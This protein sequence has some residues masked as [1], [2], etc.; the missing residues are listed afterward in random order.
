MAVPTN[1]LQ[2]GRKVY[3]KKYRTSNSDN[4]VD[5]EFGISL[6]IRIVFVKQH[7]SRRLMS[8]NVTQFHIKKM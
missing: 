8:I 3:Q 7:F 2:G 4:N 1:Q 6:T 5:I